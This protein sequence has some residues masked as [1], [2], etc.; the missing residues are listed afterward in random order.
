MKLLSALKTYFEAEPNGA[1]VDNREMLEFS[2]SLTAV[3]K[4]AAKQELRS[5][6]IN[7]VDTIEDSS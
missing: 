1:K 7:I 4:S 6:G 5:Y 3:E 2:R